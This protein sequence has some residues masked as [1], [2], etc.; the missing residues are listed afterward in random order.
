MTKNVNYTNK[1][2]NLPYEGLSMSSFSMFTNLNKMKENKL[3][4]TK[5]RQLGASNKN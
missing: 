2:I 3:G 1:V 5:K 4:K